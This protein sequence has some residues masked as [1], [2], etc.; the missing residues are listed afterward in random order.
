M[1]ED[2]L[3]I[4]CLIFKLHSCSASNTISDVATQLDSY[5]YTQTTPAYNCCNLPSQKRLI[6]LRPRSHH[7]QK[8]SH[9]PLETRH[10]RTSR[11]LAVSGIASLTLEYPQPAVMPLNY[12]KW[13]NLQVSN[14]LTQCTP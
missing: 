7:I 14:P 5:R 11:S 2:Q 13:D 6:P 4:P 1:V 10:E 9:T 12:N 3:S 8:V